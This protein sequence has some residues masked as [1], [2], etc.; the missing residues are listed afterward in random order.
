[1]TQ[2]ERCGY[3]ATKPADKVHLQE[4][5]YPYRVLWLAQRRWCHVLCAATLLAYAL[6]GWSMT[7]PATPQGLTAADEVPAPGEPPVPARKPGMTCTDAP[8]LCA[9]LKAEFPKQQ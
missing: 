3:L 1:M 2:C 5:Y 9:M 4:D 8:G 7:H 6:L